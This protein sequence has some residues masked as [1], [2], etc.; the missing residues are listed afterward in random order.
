[1]LR[2]AALKY[3]YTTCKTDPR[4]TQLADL[5]NSVRSTFEGAEYKRSML[6]KWNALSLRQIISK[7][8]DKDIETCLQLLVEELRTTQMNLDTN[9]QSDTFLQN[10]LL[11][12]CQDYL[13]CSIACLI[14]ILLSTRLIN[15]LQTSIIIYKSINKK[16]NQTQT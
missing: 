9:L 4:M 6:T 2:G 14:P 13:V 10:K 8:S 7:N 5:C 16:Q 1:M 12:A 11:M 15:N 3:Y